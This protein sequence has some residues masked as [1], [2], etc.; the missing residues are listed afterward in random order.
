[1]QEYLTLIIVLLAIVMLIYKSSQSLKTFKKSESKC[2]G[3]EGCGCG[4]K[5]C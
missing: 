3:C 1:M 4:I 5:K 2:G